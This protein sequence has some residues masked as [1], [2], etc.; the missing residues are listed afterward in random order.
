MGHP[1]RKKKTA[2]KHRDYDSYTLLICI[3]D[4]MPERDAKSIEDDRVHRI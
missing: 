4:K 1:Q 3:S 2:I